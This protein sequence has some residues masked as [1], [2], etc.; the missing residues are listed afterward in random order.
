MLHPTHGYNLDLS[1]TVSGSDSV[2]LL[3][4]FMELGAVWCPAVA[5]M[6]PNT[7]INAAD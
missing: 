2:L 3:L 7:T 1:N 5:Y 6:F 4:R